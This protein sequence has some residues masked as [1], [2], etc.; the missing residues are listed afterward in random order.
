MASGEI[1]WGFQLLPWALFF[2]NRLTASSA[3]AGFVSLAIVFSSSVSFPLVSVSFPLVS[4]SFPLVSVSF[5]LVSVPVLDGPLG[6]HGRGLLGPGE[7]FFLSF[8]EVI[9]SIN[10]FCLALMSI[11]EFL[12]LI[13]AS[14]LLP[15]R[16]FLSLPLILSLVA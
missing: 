15:N 5:P 6:D 13:L 12:L 3:E 7:G 10:S 4:V 11:E 2:F 16:V 8:S 9:L 14:Q 1:I